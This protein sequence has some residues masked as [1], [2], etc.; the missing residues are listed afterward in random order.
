MSKHGNTEPAWTDTAPDKVVSEARIPERAAELEE[1][2]SNWLDDNARYFD[3]FDWDGMKEK[4]WKKKAFNEAGTYLINAFDHGDVDHTSELKEQVIERVNDR[5]FAHLILRNQN[6]FHHFAY[7]ALYT[8]YDDALETDVATAF[9]RTAKRGEFWS[10]ERLPYRLL[11]FCYLSRIIGVQ[12]EHDE[13][14]I[15]EHSLLKHQPHIVKSNYLDAYCL[16]HD[17][18]FSNYDKMFYNNYP[19]SD[20]YDSPPIAKQYDITDVLRG[21]ILRYMAEDN[22]DITLELLLSGILQRQ[23]SREMVRLVLSWAL[24]KIETAGYIPSPPEESMYVV[25]SPKLAGIQGESPWDYEH[26]SEQET[27]WAKSY[28]TNM[29]AGMTARVLKRD[30]HKLNNRRMDHSLEDQTFRR[31]SAC[32]GHVLKSLA[33][34]D[35]AEGSRQMITLA[36]SPVSTEFPFV[37][38]EAVDFIEDQRT[39]DGAFGY[40]TDEEILYTNNG[41]TRESFRN[42]LVKSASEA[43]QEALNA[44]ETSSLK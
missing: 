6:D 1:L 37:F 26:E 42:D 41:N 5:R 34:Y 38:R 9:E 28:H 35:I 39:R 24:E 3:L 29:V 23:I 44:V 21:L 12:Y 36:E 31:D 33:H 11:E 27:I 8:A 4:F 10:S 2:A 13:E 17:V 25:S 15:V 40:W 30:W 16:T 14:T 32:L 18:M 19:G 22:L 7:P 43:C 20:G